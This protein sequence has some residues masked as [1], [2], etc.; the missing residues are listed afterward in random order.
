MPIASASL[1]LFG[2]MLLFAFFM[3]I[4]WLI[5]IFLKKKAINGATYYLVTL[6][7]IFLVHFI[8]AVVMISA[9]ILLLV[10][11]LPPIYI[12]PALTAVF[13]M[14]RFNKNKLIGANENS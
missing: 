13:F 1:L 11:I 8:A 10:V 4:S 5:N 9:P 12:L 2:L 7:I 6:G 14:R 3:L